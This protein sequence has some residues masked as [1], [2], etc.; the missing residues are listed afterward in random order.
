MENGQLDIN[1]APPT[2]LMWMA[3]IY[4]SLFLSTHK[5]IAKFR[6]FF[7][8]KGHYKLFSE[9]ILDFELVAVL[10]YILFFLISFCAIRQNSFMFWLLE[11]VIQKDGK[12]IQYRNATRFGVDIFLALFFKYGRLCEYGLFSRISVSPI[13]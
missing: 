2:E 5:S 3:E 10:D 11:I 12:G 9:N 6:H 7:N 1:P 13:T 4:L 8:L